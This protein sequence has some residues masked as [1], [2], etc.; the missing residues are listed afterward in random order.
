[1][2]KDEI[3]SKR[4]LICGNYGATNLGDD[5]I[6]AGTISQLRTKY[7]KSK[8]TALSYAPQSTAAEF[9]I[10]SFYFLPFGVRS[11]IRGIFKGELFKTLKAIKNCDLFVL[12]G[13]GLF[14]N[15]SWKA[16]AIWTLHSSVAYLY[17]KPVHMHAQSID[18]IEHKFWRTRVFNAFKKA[19]SIT[20]RDHESKQVL[21]KMGIPDAKVVSDP[22]WELQKEI[23]PS[24]KSL[25]QIA[26]S[27]RPWKGQE[28]QAI[29]ALASSLEEISQEYEFTLIPFQK[30]KSGDHTILEELSRKL[31]DLGI[32]NKISTPRNYR[33]ALKL[34]NSSK[35]VI[36][37]RLHAC[38]F[39][40]ICKKPFISISYLPKVASF[41]RSQGKAIN[42]SV[43]EITAAKLKAAIKE[44]LS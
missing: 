26:I 33:E 15:E 35:A 1:M 31:S 9:E 2:K 4:I 13:G 22:A 25:P 34:I 21:E 43:A 41:T 8:L 29:I 40:A 27:L 18:W 10:D 32:R 17:K 14:S 23:S 12:G 30:I 24:D 28:Q 44:T 36:A 37:M 11:L 16:I 7:P 39:A 38:I 42:I 3:P 5:A 20:V 6:L 19:S